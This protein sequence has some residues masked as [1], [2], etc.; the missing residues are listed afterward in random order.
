MFTENDYIAAANTEVQFADARAL[1][2]KYG[3]VV[4]LSENESNANWVNVLMWIDG[5]EVVAIVSYEPAIGGP[6]LSLAY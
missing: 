5:R 6:A 1:A 4:E 2:E 3:E